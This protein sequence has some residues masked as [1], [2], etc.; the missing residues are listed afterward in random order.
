M[1]KESARTRI[2]GMV[3]LGRSHVDPKESNHRWIHRRANYKALKE[4]VD[5]H[6][7]VRRVGSLG[8]QNM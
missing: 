5:E 6:K 7:M 2:T 8:V 1:L 4:D 3:V